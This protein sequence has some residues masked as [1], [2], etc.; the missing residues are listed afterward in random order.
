MNTRKQ[1]SH[2]SRQ[3]PKCSLSLKIA[4]NAPIAVLLRR[5]PTGWVQMIR[6]DL[7]TDSFTEGQWFKGRIYAELSELSPD[8]ELLLYSARKG[9]AWTLARTD[10]V[11]ET[12]TAISRPPYFTALGLWPNGCW[13]GG[14]LFNELRSVKLGLPFPKA[15]NSFTQDR[16]KVTGTQE[17]LH[18]PLSLQIALQEGWQPLNQSPESLNDYHWQLNTCLGKEI[19]QGAVRITRSVRQ[20]KHWKLHKRFTVSNVHNQWDLGEVDLVDFDTRGRL[21][22]STDG[23]L[24]VCD[25]PTEPELRWRELAN[26][27]HNKPQPLP[28]PDWA[29]EWPPVSNREE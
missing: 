5:G 6:W 17:H 7:R 23:R 15:Q 20:G 27:A 28:P 1:D 25:S 11:G 29:K 2:V 14:G 8:G 19:G 24:M 4:R 12:W 9:N 3:R 13:D 10:G 22:L 26:F 16:L 21:I 18:Q